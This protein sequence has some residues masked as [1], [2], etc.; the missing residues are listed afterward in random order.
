MRLINIGGGEPE[1]DTPSN[2]IEAMKQAMEDGYTHYGDFRHIPELREAVAAKYKRYGVDVDPELVIITPGSTM[3]IYMAY[4]ALMKPGEEFIVMDPCFFGYFLAV[5][6]QGIKPVPVPRS[7]D[8]WSFNIE[9]VYKATTD[10]TRAVLICSPDNPT[11]AVLSQK[12]LKELAEYSV[13]KDVKIISDDIYDEILYDGAKFKSI[14]ALPGM[15][16]RT[17]ILNGLSKTYAMTGWRVG[18]IIPP[19]KETYDMLF[20]LQ[21]S[22]YLVLNQALQYASLEALTG[23]QDSVKKMVEGYREKREYVVDAWNDMPKVS[24]TKPKGAFYAFPDLSGYGLSSA[25]MAEYIKKEA[26]VAITPGRLFGA[27][28]EGHIRNSFAQSMD[29]LSEGLT[30]IKAALSKL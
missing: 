21:M 26:N 15:K 6:E 5:K 29:D 2:I 14:A 20:S 22:T 13:E 9:D 12:E 16:E 10:K 3:G 30:R 28:G 7:G 11:G 8:D 18:Y 19:D 25:K 24:I 4:K 17:I 1:Y 27:Q 23:P